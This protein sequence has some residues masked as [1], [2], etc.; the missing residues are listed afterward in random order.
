MES[1]KISVNKK[2]GAKQARLSL[3]NKKSVVEIL[4][5]AAY[6][7]APRMEQD[8]LTKVDLK[9]RNGWKITLMHPKN[10]YTT[11][12][13]SVIQETLDQVV[14]DLPTPI[15]RQWKFF[16]RQ[17]ELEQRGNTAQRVLSQRIA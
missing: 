10:H 17:Q 11:M 12:P 1:K 4:A 16:L 5:D 7:I 13:L 15:R 9:L 6:E 8:K 3:G 14:E 2:M